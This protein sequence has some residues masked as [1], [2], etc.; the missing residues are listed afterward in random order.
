[1]R[2]CSSGSVL[3][4][5]QGNVVGNQGSWNDD[6]GMDNLRM[7]CT[8][9]DVLDG[10]YGTPSDVQVPV[11]RHQTVVEGRDVEA[12]HLKLTKEVRDHGDWGSWARCTPGKVVCG[13]QTR[14]EDE[15]VLNDD[16]G[17][18]DVVIYCCNP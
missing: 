13:L 2:T 9:G 6:L 11:L 7:E 10:W 12:V 4:G 5:M 14:V 15:D 8:N 16:A 3:V 18:C 17:M 1:M